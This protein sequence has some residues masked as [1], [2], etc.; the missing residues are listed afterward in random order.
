MPLEDKVRVAKMALESCWEIYEESVMNNNNKDVNSSERE[1]ILEKR[2]NQVMKPHEYRLVI[3]AYDCG[4]ACVLLA[5]EDSVSVQDSEAWF[6]R[7]LRIV[8]EKHFC[9]LVGNKSKHFD[10]PFCLFPKFFSFISRRI[11][12]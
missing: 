5:E 10:L 6:R 11:P 3:P 7:A 2:D 9:L 12:T 1:K 4:L 8:F